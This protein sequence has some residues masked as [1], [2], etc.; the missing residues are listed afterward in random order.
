[1]FYYVHYRDNWADEMFVEGFSI[2]DEKKYERYT[3]T[4][5]AI[6]ADIECG[7]PFSYWIGSNEEIE[8]SNVNDFLSAFEVSEFSIIPT[9]FEMI[10]GKRF[11]E[12]GFFPFEQMLNTLE[13]R[14][15]EENSDEDNDEMRTEYYRID[16]FG[17]LSRER[18]GDPVYIKVKGYFETEIDAQ[19]EAFEEHFA[20]EYHKQ[21]GV[22]C[23]PETTQ[24]YKELYEQEMNLYGNE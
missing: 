3:A 24:I 17:S 6:V 9:D 22:F 16:F 15:E 13:E 2:M 14:A 18:I 5:N 21:Y 7:R 1:M 23:Y 11:P 20:T 4:V 10:F 8:Y 12:F 19:V